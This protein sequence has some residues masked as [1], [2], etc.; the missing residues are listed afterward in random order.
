MARGARRGQVG[1]D[2]AVSAVHAAI[3]AGADDLARAEVLARLMSDAAVQGRTE[4]TLDEA[5]VDR[6]TNRSPATPPR[7][8]PHRTAEIYVRLGRP[9]G[10]RGRTHGPA[11]DGDDDG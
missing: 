10:L 5:T 6:L 8:A 7:T 1:Q 3:G 9:G 4:I 11:H 2:E